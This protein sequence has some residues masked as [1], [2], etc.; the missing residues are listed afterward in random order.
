MLLL[1][2]LQRGGYRRAPTSPADAELDLGPLLRVVHI[3]GQRL[4][5]VTAPL[6][7]P[8]P[9]LSYDALLRSFRQLCG[10]AG[11]PTTAGLHA[12][13][14]GGATS[15]IASGADRILVQKL[16]RWRS[17]EVF[18]GSYVRESAAERRAL[19]SRLFPPVSVAG[20]A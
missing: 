11:L 15:Y 19:T 16:G 2:L 12:L 20:P 6:R 14:R 9:P 8:I 5:Q 13:R 18:E 4:L 10:A 17:S 7:N 3:D 1:A